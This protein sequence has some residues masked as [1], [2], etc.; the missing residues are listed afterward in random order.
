MIGKL[1]EEP[2]A[3]PRSIGE[4]TGLAAAMEAEAVAR[5]EQLAAE[6][7]RQGESVLAATFRTLLEEERHHDAQVAAWSLEA[8]GAPPAAARWRLPADIARSWQ[9][10]ADSALLT[11]YRAL[12]IAVLNEERGFAFYTYIAAHAQDD[13]IRV[14]A[15]R[16]ALEEM[17][18]AATLRR[19]RR[20]AYRCA[21]PVAKSHFAELDR[22][23]EFRRAASL[24]EATAAAAHEYLAACLLQ[25]GDTESARILET[26]ADAERNVAAGIPFPP[27]TGSNH[28]SVE[29]RARLLRQAVAAS[30]QLYDAY[31][32]ALELSRNEEVRREAEIRVKRVTKQL[33]LIAARLHTPV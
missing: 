10:V 31:A 12:A 18:H 32:D 8:T 20:R 7:E 28:V 24:T 6:M 17:G 30:E 23:V 16:L 19:L 4:L 1:T 27:A 3:R 5:Y 13:G 22:L 26:I 33:A 2:S 14:C 21:H 29:E 25:I 11:P 15:E 9:E